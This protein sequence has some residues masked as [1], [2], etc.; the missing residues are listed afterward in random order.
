MKSAIKEFDSIMEK[1]IEKGSAVLVIADIM[2]DKAK[3]ALDVICERLK[4]GDS[5]VYFLNNKTPEFVK[6]NIKDWKKFRSSVFIVDAFSYSV[7]KKSGERFS[8][9]E[10]T[11]NV[12]PH[13]KMSYEVLFKAMERPEKGNVIVVLDSL[14]YW[15]GHWKELKGFIQKSKKKTGKNMVCFHLLA[16][17]NFKKSDVERYSKQFDYVIRLKAPSGRSRERIVFERVSK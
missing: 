11:V 9:K 15:I 7:G 14:D 17:M 13:I 2:A 8:V 1:K 6:E 12:V 4:R 3:F 5:V 16:D 10:K